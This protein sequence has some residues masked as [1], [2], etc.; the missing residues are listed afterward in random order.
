MSDTSTKPGW[1]TTEATL[2]TISGGS[3][4]MLA[5]GHENPWVVGAACVSFAIIACGYL[6]ARTKAKQG[7]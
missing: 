4:F 2:A 3:I 7:V 1:K 6:W 5:D